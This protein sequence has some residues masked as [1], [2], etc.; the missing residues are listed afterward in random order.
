[1][2]LEGGFAATAKHEEIAA[3]EKIMAELLDGD[4]HARHGMAL[5][6]AHGDGATGLAMF[7]NGGFGLRGDVF[8]GAF[9]L[10]GG[11]VRATQDSGGSAGAEFEEGASIHG[12]RKQQRANFA[13]KNSL[14]D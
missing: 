10:L 5:D 11:S 14:F 7:F 13:S 12:T 8:I 2:F 1:L 3:E 4:P 9:E 6:I